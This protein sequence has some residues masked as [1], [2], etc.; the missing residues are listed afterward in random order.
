[1]EEHD[2]AVRIRAFRRALEKATAAGAHAVEFTSEPA[3]TGKPVFTLTGKGLDDR[4]PKGLV[5]DM[6]ALEALPL[7]SVRIDDPWE[8]RKVTYRGV[9]MNELMRAIDPAGA[10]KMRITALDDYVVTVQMKDLMSGEVLLA[11]TAEGKRMAVA[12]GG[13]TRLI[14]LPK[15]VVGKS[16]DMWIWSIS[17][18]ALE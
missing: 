16:T 2:A 4:F 8:K 3:L 11:T 15:S 17:E 18:M 12:D 13:P 14:L 5:L 10:T 7:V 9:M 6:A 1:M